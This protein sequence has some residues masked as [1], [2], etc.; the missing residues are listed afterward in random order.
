[1]KTPGGMESPI[2][3]RNI[4]LG[5]FC[6]LPQDVA[7]LLSDQGEDH[8]PG[9]AWTSVGCRNRLGIGNERCSGNES[10]SIQRWPTKRKETVPL[11]P[12]SPLS[13]DD[14]APA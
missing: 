14:S 9:L 3:I 8:H 5:N 11:R 1:M 7:C 6:I 10:Q 2:T 13:S 4:M 12:A